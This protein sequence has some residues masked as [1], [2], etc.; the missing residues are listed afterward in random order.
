MSHTTL[1]I[2]YFNFYFS[3]LALESTVALTIFGLNPK[4]LNS[5]DKYATTLMNH[6]TVG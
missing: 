6:R 2:D 5:G 4:E 3:A 1:K